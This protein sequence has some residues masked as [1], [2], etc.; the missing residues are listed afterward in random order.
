MVLYRLFR[1]QICGRFSYQG[2]P[3]NTRQQYFQL[4]NQAIGI[5]NSKW[6]SSFRTAKNCFI[7][8]IKHLS[9]QSFSKEASRCSVKWFPYKIW[10]LGRFRRVL[11]IS[12]FFANL[13]R[14]RSRVLSLLGS[15]SSD[16]GLA[17]TDV[18]VIDIIRFR[19]GWRNNWKFESKHSF[20]LMLRGGH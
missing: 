4:Y 6:F 17:K 18:V 14:P 12:Q 9:Q 15:T 2:F 10:S 8:L 16:R 11:L 19:Y 3:Y 5:I 7:K 20:G 13:W 1:R